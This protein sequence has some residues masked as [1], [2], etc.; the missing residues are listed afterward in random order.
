MCVAFGQYA[1]LCRTCMP[2]V[3]GGQKRAPETLELE[4]CLVVGHLV[5]AGDQT[6]VLWKSSSVL[7]PAEPSLSSLGGLT[8]L[9]PGLLVCLRCPSSHWLC[10]NPLYTLVCSAVHRV[11][12]MFRNSGK[13]LD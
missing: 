6:P 12:E 13:C 2:D 1:C 8:P 4:L 10:M 7:F 3:L 9:R 11:S 5:G